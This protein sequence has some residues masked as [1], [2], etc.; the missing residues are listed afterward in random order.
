MDVFLIVNCIYIIFSIK[1]KPPSFFQNFIKIFFLYF[2][3][4]IIQIALCFQSNF[5][6]FFDSI[7]LIF[8]VDNVHKS[9][10]NFHIG[11]LY[12]DNLLK[13]STTLFTTLHYIS[14]VFTKI[15]F[16]RQKI[17]GYEVFHTLFS[18]CSDISNI[19]SCFS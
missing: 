11:F 19:I 16:Y 15:N 2:F 3:Y 9:V 14:T 12:V 6:T 10:H 13:F 17:T 8:S 4:K 7:F 5:S 18:C 1:T